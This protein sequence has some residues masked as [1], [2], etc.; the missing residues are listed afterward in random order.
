MS[1]AQY[2][3]F[4]RFWLGGLTI[5][6]ISDATVTLI[7]NMVQ[8]QYPA[9]TECQVK[10]YFI[11]ATL[12]FLIRE[13]AK[14]KSGSAGSGEVSERREKRGSTEVLEKYNVG[15]TSSTTAGWDKVL[16]KL[17]ADPNSIG[18]TPF[19]TT[20]GGTGSSGRSGGSVIIGGTGDKFSTKAPWRETSLGKR[21]KFW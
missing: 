9:A 10:Y 12:E 2:I 7:L 20:S 13:S 15:S 5:S 18:C 17:I 21:R 4:L 3:A 6:D 1:Q 19:P 14:A 8:S 16:E 11:K